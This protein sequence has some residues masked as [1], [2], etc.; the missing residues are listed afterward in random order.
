M[1][2]SQHYAQPKTRFTS[3]FNQWDCIVFTLFF[4]LMAAIVFAADNMT[5]T[6]QL[7]QSITISTDPR[8]LPEYALATVMRMTLALGC[9]LLFTLMVGS[10]AAKSKVA[11][12]II[13]PFIDIMQSVPV[14][15]F[16]SFTVLLFIRLFPGSQLG[17][18]CAAIFAI[19]TSQVW[20][21][22]L[23]F[24]QSLRMVPSDL[25]EAAAMFNLGPWQKFWRIEVP[26]ATPGLIWNTMMSLSAGWFFVVASEAISVANQ[27]IMLP[28]IGSYIK[29]AQEQE[30]YTALGYAILTMLIV[31]ML[32]DQLLFRP[33]ITWS[34]QF[35]SEPDE[36]SESSSWFLTL[37]RRSK[38]IKIINH[39]LSRIRN[40]IV[41][42]SVFLAKQK[43][44]LSAPKTS[45]YSLNLPPIF[46][47]MLTLLSTILL[48]ASLL[49]SIS[50]V[51]R[52]IFTA[53]GP[54]EILRVLFLGLITTIK[55]TILIIV[56]SIIW[57]PIG[58][59]V[60]LHPKLSRHV[61]PLA[62]FLAAFPAN[63]VY[64]LVFLAIINYNLNVEIWTAPLMILGTQWYI[65]F[66]VIAGTRALPID[67]K[68]AAQN[69]QIK[70]W[71]WWKK[72][73]LPSIFPYYITGAMT[74]AG[75]CW[76][77][78]I[79]ADVVEW[80]NKR[81]TA[82]GLGSYI[83]EFTTT[84]DFPRITLGIAVMCLYVTLIN[85]LVW[86]NLYTLAETRYNVS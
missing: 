45:R 56:S 64:P 47:R 43:K 82:T 77:A 86:R 71:L 41:H 66:N 5:N 76:N 81:I 8:Y 61:Q 78:S 18:E 14:L 67:L 16:L 6:Y 55:V 9:S 35:Q 75:G 58:V 22:T 25:K 34:E 79:L 30:N 50:L 3:I 10:L 4:G 80:G 26:F 46:Y 69:Y 1:Q 17:P 15:G 84:A 44:S 51:T 37:M 42:P 36:D 27:N 74:A 63:L 85:R 57:V 39:S 68:Y 73:I 28:G 49:L 62:Q 12:K 65:L 83:T 70:G 13:I 7:G 53:V 48:I 21:M 11:E 33:L 59:W 54:R 52:F 20:N 40:F 23:S 19:F 24:Y 38:L 31:I 29:L 2:E 72:I 60:G 32:Y